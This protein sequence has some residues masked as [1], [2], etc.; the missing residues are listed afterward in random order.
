M[1]GLGP[2]ALTIWTISWTRWT[3][4]GAIGGGQIDHNEALA[5]DADLI[6]HGPDAVGTPAGAEVAFL[7][8]TAA[9]EAAGDE[10]AVDALFEGREDV[11]HFDF[12]GTGRCG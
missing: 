10:H 7:E 2:R 1:R 3:N 5:A 11:L 12:A 9:L 6:K 4:V 8:V